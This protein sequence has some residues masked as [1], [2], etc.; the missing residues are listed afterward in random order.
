MVLS[1]LVV[2]GDTGS[3]SGLWDGRDLFRYEC[4]KCKIRL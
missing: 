2:F 1:N 3:L 4:L